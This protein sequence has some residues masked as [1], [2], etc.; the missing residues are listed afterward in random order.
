MPW[1]DGRPLL[2]YALPPGR[3]GLPSLDLHWRIHWNETEL[4]RELLARAVPHE[5]G[6][7]RLQPADEL[8]S[9]LLFFGRNSLYGLR[10]VTDAGAS[11][12]RHQDELPAGFLA[13]VLEHRPELRDTLAASVLAAERLVG[14]PRE[15]LGP[16]FAP[17]RRALLASRLANWQMTGTEAERTDNMVSVDWLLSPPGQWRAFA[18]RHMFQPTAALGPRLLH[19]VAR[20]LKFAFRHVRVRWRIRGGRAWCPTPARQ[21]QPQGSTVQNVGFSSAFE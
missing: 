11:W 10:L 20:T 2:H 7:R 21:P 9:L 5:R 12:D 3:P 13:P 14:L 6:G 1:Q 19:G 4:S 8:L 16:S 18:R 15:L 17:S